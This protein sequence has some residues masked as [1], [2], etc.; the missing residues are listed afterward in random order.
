VNEKIEEQNEERQMNR[1]AVMPGVILIIVGLIFLLPQFGIGSANGLWPAFIL[2]PGLG[3][4]AMWLTSKNKAKDAGLL[5][6]GTIITLI[7]AFFFYL[8]WAGWSKMAN[9]W[10]IFPLIVGIAFYKF[11]FASGR[12]D[13]GILVPANILLLVGLFFLILQSY[14]YKLWP[15]ILILLGILMIVAGKKE[16]NRD[17]EEN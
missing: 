13:R 10:P 2:A 16:K 7:S 15:I 3:F 8:N 6:P 1:G 11:F 5:I 12:R 17:K 14:T 4:I 9:L